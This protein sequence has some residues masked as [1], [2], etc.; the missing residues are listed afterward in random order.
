MRKQDFLFDQGV[1]KS[2]DYFKSL[3]RQTSALQQALGVTGA[4]GLA[5]AVEAGT[6]E[7]QRSLA[8]AE[9]RQSFA[10]FDRLENL[11]A[12]AN[13]LAEEQNALLQEFVDKNFEVIAAGF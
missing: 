9:A 11:L 10:G 2:E 3:K 1:I 13:S 7:A 12:L 5:T 8:E 6:A 4:P